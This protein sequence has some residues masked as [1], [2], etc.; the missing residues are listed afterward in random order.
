MRWRNREGSKNIEDRRGQ[1]GRFGFPLPGG[2]GRRMR[3]PGQRGG[4]ISL[5][6]I[7]ILL[8]FMYFTGKCDPGLILRELTRGQGQI[9]L[10]GGVEG[11]RQ[12]GQLPKI[13]TEPLPDTGRD[14]RRPGDMRV[15]TLFFSVS[16]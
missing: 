13:D 8:A 16:G 2:R 1:G 3:M 14:F 5:W 7:L 4:G 12:P 9:Q 11:Q 10:P 6:T 15:R